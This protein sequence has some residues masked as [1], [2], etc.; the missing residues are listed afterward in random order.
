[1]H[2]VSFDIDG[3]GLA[4]RDPIAVACSAF[5]SAFRGRLRDQAE[6]VLMR[7]FAAID[8]FARPVAGLAEFRRVDAKNSNVLHVDRQGITGNYLHLVTE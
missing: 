7:N 1:M 8:G 6:T 2:P 4:C 5:A 3:F